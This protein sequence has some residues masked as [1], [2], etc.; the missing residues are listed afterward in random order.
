MSCSHLCSPSCWNAA[1]LGKKILKSCPCS[2][3][4][5]DFHKASISPGMWEKCRWLP[6]RNLSSSNRLLTS[7]SEWQLLRIVFL[8]GPAWPIIDAASH[9]GQSRYSALSYYRTI[10][11]SSRTWR[12]SRIPL[13]IICRRVA[14][15]FIQHFFDSKVGVN[16]S[17]FL[18]FKKT[19]YRGPSLK[20]PIFNCAL[21][22]KTQRLTN[23]HEGFFCMLSGWER[24]PFG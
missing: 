10:V 18:Q 6:S 22:K 9:D 2:S 20:R 23:D 11:R 15:R 4:P 3:S 1:A 14:N 8:A 21:N 19:R 7:L 16:S 24:G 13:S 17:R 12:G 5:I